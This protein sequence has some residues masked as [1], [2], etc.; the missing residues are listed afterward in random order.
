ARGA[1]ALDET[2]RAIAADVSGSVWQVLVEPGE[3]VI[4]GQVV[5]IVE[6]MKME[7]AVTAT[8]DGMIE[9]IDCAPGVAV[10]AGQRLMVLKAGAAEE[11]A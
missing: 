2:Q 1:G 8:E 7:V 9:A 3:R 6:S 11:V 4:E 5:A 10:V